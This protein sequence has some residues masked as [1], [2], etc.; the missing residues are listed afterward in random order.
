MRCIIILGRSFDDTY[1]ENDS[2]IRFAFAS[3]A[4]IKI[5]MVCFFVFVFFPDQTYIT[6]GFQVS[7][8]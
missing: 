2:R 1:K 8:C 7:N 6:Y 5:F 4:Q 3:L